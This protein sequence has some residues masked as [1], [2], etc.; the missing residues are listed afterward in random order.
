MPATG[1]AI[2][3][4][5]HLIKAVVP[6]IEKTYP[7]KAEPS[8]RRLLGFSKSG[9]GAYSLLLR[10]L[11]FFGGAAAF[12]S[13][14]LLSVPDKYGSGEIFG[15]LANFDTYRPDELL[16]KNVGGIKR[17]KDAPRFVLLGKANFL[18]DGRFI[19]ET[20]KAMSIEH[21]Y[22]EESEYPHRWGGGWLE[23]AAT[24]LLK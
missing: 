2:R 11:D 22:S 13:P 19:H 23:L 4:E 21:F 20:M 17:N 14:F 9:W 18:I 6:F 3:Q 12:D 5:S 10:H 8:G 7:A 24:E 1:T 16:R 15:T